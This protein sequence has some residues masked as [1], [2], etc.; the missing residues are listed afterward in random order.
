[1]CALIIPS[2]ATSY[3]SGGKQF[4]DTN[5]FSTGAAARIS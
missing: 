1:M 3:S 2:R 4:R 5:T